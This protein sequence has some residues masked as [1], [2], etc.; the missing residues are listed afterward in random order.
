MIRG[1]T[2]GV[3]QIKHCKWNRD[4]DSIFW[5]E[6]SNY[7]ETLAA[8]W[9]LIALP[10]IEVFCY[11]YLNRHTATW[12]L[13]VLNNRRSTFWGFVL[14]LT[15][16]KTL[17]LPFLCSVSSFSYLWTTF[18]KLLNETVTSLWHSL[19]VFTLSSSL[20]KWSWKILFIA[21]YRFHSPEKEAQPSGVMDGED[22][23]EI[24]VRLVHIKAPE[25]RLKPLWL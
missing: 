8:H 7:E 25:T 14:I 21:F 22:I 11:L 6:W 1:L 13:F 10:H 15:V 5:R 20:Y 2:S 17:K 3:R 24:N 9:T 18:A 19:C 12:N 23:D 4:F 16:S